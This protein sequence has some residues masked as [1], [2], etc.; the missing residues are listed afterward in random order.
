MLFRSKNIISKK[1]MK[2]KVDVSQV[3]IGKKLVKLGLAEE[4]KTCIAA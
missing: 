2:I 4:N 1:E 3:F